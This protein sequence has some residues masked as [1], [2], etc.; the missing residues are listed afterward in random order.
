MM[1]LL[2]GGDTPNYAK[3]AA[4]AEKWRQANILQGIDLINA[5]FQG[6]TAPLYTPF[7][8]KFTGQEW[9]QQGN[10]GTYYS[11]NKQGEFSPYFAPKRE[12]KGAGAA[13]FAPG[14]GDLINGGSFGDAHLSAISGG[15]IPF[16]SGLFGDEPS[17]RDLVN[18][19]IKRGNL[20]TKEDKT[21]QGFG[22]DFYAAREK[23]YMDY[24]LPELA[25]QYRSQARQTGF[26]LH[27]RGLFGS[28]AG[29]QAFSDV[30][31]AN[32]GGRRAIADTARA[33]SQDLRRQ[34][35]GARSSLISQLYQS[36]SPAQG[37][38]SAIDTAA[39]FAVPSSFAPV[40]NFFSNLVNQYAVKNVLNPQSGGGFYG[41]APSYFTGALPSSFT[42]NKVG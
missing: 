5:V 12:E 38:R 40:G 41:N 30:E 18:K 32:L 39:G 10:D 28:S 27:N 16:I 21:Y 26:G 1:E 20:Y 23:A 2:F 8:D 22:P 31:R 37:L 42:S 35:E 11:V 13:S 7:S 24:A 4:K 17:E 6:G 34:I 25:E 36:A 33:G 14:L 9:K 29:Q 15:S 3:K 19:Q